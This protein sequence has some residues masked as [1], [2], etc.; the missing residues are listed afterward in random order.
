MKKF[1]ISALIVAVFGLYVFL[2]KSSGHQ[3]TAP[4]TLTSTANISYKDGTYT[5]PTTDAYYGSVQ[6]QVTVSGG[7]IADVAFLQYPSDRSTSQSINGQAMPYL[8]QEALAAQSANV[9]IISGATDT[10]QAF[11]QSLAAALAQAQG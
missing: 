7:K 10:S 8:K 4:T 6:V 11:Q 5:G 3:V 1:L 9:N 2:Q